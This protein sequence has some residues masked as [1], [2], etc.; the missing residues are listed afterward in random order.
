MT[1]ILKRTTMCDALR[2]TDI[3]ARVTVCGW[4]Q[5]NRRL[6][7]LIFCDLRDRSGIL[8]V[9]FDEDIPREVFALAETLRSEYVVG[10]AGVLRE[11]ASKNHDLATGD[12]ELLAETL[13][14]YSK[15]ETP[16]I[17]IRDDDNADEN[18]RLKYRYLDL[19]KPKMQRNLRVRHEI[20]RVT[21]EYFAEQGFTEVET[22]M[23]IRPTPEGARDYL[24]PSRVHNGAFYALPQSPQMYKQL[25]M[26][27]GVDR[28]MQIVKCFRDEDLRADRQPE[29]TQI[30]LEMSFVDADDVMAVQEGYLKRLMKTV[31]DVDIEIPFPRYTYAEAMERFGSDKPDTRFGLEL[32]DISARVRDCAF[33]VFADAVRGG[34]SVRG[35]CVP[36]G[37]SAFSRKDIDRLTEA[38]RVYGARGLAW[39]KVTDEGIGTSFSKFFDAQELNELTECFYGKPGDLILIAAGPDSVVFAALGFLRCEIA[40]R[41]NLADKDAWNFLWVVDFPLLEKDAETGAYKAMHHPFTAPNPE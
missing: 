7:G 41:M 30:D 40:E 26:V 18:L 32:T 24:V 28:Y 15:A 35:I 19:R 11:R 5:K 8:Q 21:R 9:V 23:L 36:G 1:E 12:V 14:V 25:L 29:F 22:P 2:I 3:G 39:M 38:V 33:G 6:G 37:A 20:A 17:Y 4:V 10:I 27:G 13:C 34:G 16:P 31:R